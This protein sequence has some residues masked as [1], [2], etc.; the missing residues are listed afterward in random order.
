MMY[1]LG[2][3]PPYG[4]LSHSSGVCTQYVYASSHLYM[5]KNHGTLRGD[6]IVWKNIFGEDLPIEERGGILSDIRVT[7]SKD[8]VT[9]SR[10]SLE[11]DNGIYKIESTPPNSWGVLIN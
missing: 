2:I 1:H 11:S 7:I 5:D 3:F 4:N 9:I 10:S 8:S 6:E